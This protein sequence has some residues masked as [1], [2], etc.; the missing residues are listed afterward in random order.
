MHY[1]ASRIAESFKMD[2]FVIWSEDNAD[3]LIIRYRVL[4]G[5][6]KDDDGMGS[7]EDIFLRQLENTM[8]NSVSLRGVK[9]IRKVFLLQHD[10][11]MIEDDGSINVRKKEEWVLETEGVNLKTVMCINGVDF[12]RTYSNN[13]V[14]VFNVLG[15]EAARAAI[16][17]ELRNVIKFNGSYV[18]YRHLALLC[19]L[20]THR[21]SLMAI[22]CH[23]I[24][25]ADTGALMRCSFEET[26]EILMEAAAVGEKD[27]CHGVAENVMF[28]QMA[29]MGTGAFE[30]VLDID[31]LKDAIVDHRLPVQSMLA[32]QVDGGMTPGQVAMTLYDT[33][34]PVWQDGVFKGDQASFSPLAVNGGDDGP[35]FTTFQ[36]GWGQT[37]TR[38]YAMSPGPQYSPSS[39]N[40]VFGPEQVLGG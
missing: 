38:A 2:L 37:P 8:L 7:I 10:K 12:K 19:D 14:E 39:P 40:I 13:C 5:G 30:V 34:S 31:M 15:I 32:A 27:D 28:G 6:D 36:S 25:H 22:T 26:F 35:S 9:D 21:G 3:K 1:V 20:M 24:N 16:L 17:K 18:N 23:G 11:T 29:P 4:G 33:N